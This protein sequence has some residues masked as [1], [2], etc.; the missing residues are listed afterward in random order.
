VTLSLIKL[1]LSQEKMPWTHPHPLILLQSVQIVLGTSNKEVYNQRCFS[2]EVLQW[3]FI[4]D[5][6]RVSV[7]GKTS[8]ID[9]KPTVLLAR[10]VP[11][12]FEATW[13]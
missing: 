3:S 7:L 12:F 8:I 13:C 2:L 9:A 11:I 10:V 4:T 6:G 5:Q 1:A